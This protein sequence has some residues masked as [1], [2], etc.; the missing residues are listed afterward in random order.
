MSGIAQYEMPAG[1]KQAQG[2]C[3][4]GAAGVSIVLGSRVTLAPTVSLRC[5]STGPCGSPSPQNGACEVLANIGEGP[6]AR[7]LLLGGRRILE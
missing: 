6:P 2:D 3:L 5:F 4:L 7:L 1:L